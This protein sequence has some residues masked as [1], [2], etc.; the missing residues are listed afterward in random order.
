MKPTHHLWKYTVQPGIVH[1]SDKLLEMFSCVP[2]VLP[3]FCLDLINC[4]SFTAVLV[5]A[6]CIYTEKF[7]YSCISPAHF[8]QFSPCHITQQLCVE[9]GRHH[10]EY[11]SGVHSRGE[12]SAW[13]NASSQV[14][15]CLP[16]EMIQNNFSTLPWTSATHQA[17]QQYLMVNAEVRKDEDGC[18]P[19]LHWQ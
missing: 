17:R 13:D 19:S 18:L 2:S 11:R 10:K 5:V 7:R 1:S 8:L 9:T 16:A 4:F 12:C 14:R 15:R 3:L 6:V